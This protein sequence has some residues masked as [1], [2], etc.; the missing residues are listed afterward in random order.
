M[1]NPKDPIEP[2]TENPNEGTV[3]LEDLAKG[4][5][6]DD[7]RPP[8]SAEEQAALDEEAGKR[9]QAQA[10]MQAVMVKISYGLFK[11]TRSA[12]ARKLP[13]IRE[14]WT[15]DVLKEPADALVP[16]FNKYAGLLFSKLGDKP[17]LAVLAFSLLPMVFGYFDAVDRHELR[18]QKDA[19]RTVDAGPVDHG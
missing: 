18:L 12:V 8:I 15:D 16:V 6:S 19:A 4:F 10:A 1:K 11:A 13:E 3:S 5:E 2:V 9:E 14:E 17:E 7:L